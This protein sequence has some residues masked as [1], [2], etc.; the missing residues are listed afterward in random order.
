MLLLQGN[1]FVSSYLQTDWF[2]KLVFWALFLLSI[3]S[4]V[5]LIYRTWILFQVRKQGKELMDQFSPKEPLQLQF[6]RPLTGTLLEVPHPFFAIYKAFKQKA[7]LLMQGQRF[8][9][10]DLSLVEAQLQVAINSQMKLLE[11]HL[12]I[13]STIT[14][15]GPFLGLLGTVWG[16]LMTFSQ[17]GLKTAA[18]HQLLSGLSLALAATV[19][20]LVVAIPSLVGF[21]YLKNSLRELKRDLEE[22]SYLL[23]SSLEIRYRSSSVEEPASL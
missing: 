23:I 20:G 14:T 21:N 3:L 18:S 17:M 5:I 8:S 16:I 19:V 4:W 1:P 7:L 6:A 11:K 12:F 10:S 9:E 15:L 2:G 22:F 13:L